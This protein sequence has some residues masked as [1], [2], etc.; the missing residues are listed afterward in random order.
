MSVPKSLRFVIKRHA[1][2]PY[3]ECNVKYKSGGAFDFTGA[4]GVTFSM[5]DDEGVLTIDS[6]AAE[7]ADANPTLGKLRYKWEA[8][9]TDTSGDYTAEF[10]VIYPASENMTLPLDGDINVKIYADVNNA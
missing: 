4:S 8:G 5:K 10:D 3:I 1:R 9:D 6:K 2:R 7:F